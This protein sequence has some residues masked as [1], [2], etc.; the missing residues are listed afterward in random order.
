[1]DYRILILSSAVFHQPGVENT[2]ADLYDAHGL[3]R[4]KIGRG[5][6]FQ[7]SQATVTVT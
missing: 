6:K 3:L 4:D 7:N 5:E 1:M 2:N